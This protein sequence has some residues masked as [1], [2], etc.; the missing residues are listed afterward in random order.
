MR[1]Q[2][3]YAHPV[4]GSFCSALRDAATRALRQGGHDVHVSDLY[5]EAFQPALSR[6]ERVGYETPATGNEGIADYVAQ[7][8]WAEGLVLVF[9]TWWYGMPAILKGY[10]DRVWIP[11]VAFDLDGRGG[12]IRRRLGHIR[13]LV[14]IT[15][16]GSPRWFIKMWMR[17]PGKRVLTRG[18]GR[19]LRP[20]ARHVYLARYNMDRAT[21]SSRTRFVAKVER[22][23]QRL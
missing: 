5:A 19:L 14:V 7:L 10:F 2:L 9:P 16:Y 23:L 21:A 13:V 3:I 15:T 20:R 6:E 12:L 4:E 22:T 8:R 11:G 17:D 18:L 1:V